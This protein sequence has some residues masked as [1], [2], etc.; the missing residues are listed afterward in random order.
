M[1]FGKLKYR[2]PKIPGTATDTE[3]EGAMIKSMRYAK[4]VGEH[5]FL[6]P[7][8]LKFFRSLYKPKTVEN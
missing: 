4:K 6:T 1:I 2:E 5:P 7:S 3:K 8:K